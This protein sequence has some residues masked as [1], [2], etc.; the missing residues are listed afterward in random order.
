[1]RSCQT[2]H[3]NNT[4]QGIILLSAAES[5]LTF[6]NILEGAIQQK[7]RSQQADRKWQ[8]YNEKIG[9][10]TRYLNYLNQSVCSWY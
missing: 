2:R 6:K 4:L 1:M 9:E 10:L 3:V 7:C 8:E 5:K